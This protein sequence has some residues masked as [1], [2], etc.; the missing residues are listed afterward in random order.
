LVWPWVWIK[1]RPQVLGK[2]RW[3]QKEL[4]GFSGASGN[5][6]AGPGGMTIKAKPSGAIY[7]FKSWLIAGFFLV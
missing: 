5:K 4:W 2:R 6:E 7:F 1:D 3:R